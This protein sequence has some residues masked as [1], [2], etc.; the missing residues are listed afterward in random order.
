MAKDP[1][2]ITLEAHRL[3]ENQKDLGDK[4]WQTKDKIPNRYGVYG[5]KPPKNVL[6]GREPTNVTL[7]L[8][9]WYKDSDDEDAEF[10]SN[11]Y[12]GPTL[13]INNKM[14]PT[15]QG[16]TRPQNQELYIAL[17]ILTFVAV[18]LIGGTFCYNRSIRRIDVGNVMSRKRHGHGLR[19]SRTPIFARKRTS[20]DERAHMLGDWDGQERGEGLPVLREEMERSEQEWNKRR[21]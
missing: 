9:T 20:S 1:I 7:V 3:G 6:H 19:K 2:Q 10:K 4:R 14:G 17:P 21:F 8:R 16:V 5:W 13:L 11:E 15:L 12:I 18:L